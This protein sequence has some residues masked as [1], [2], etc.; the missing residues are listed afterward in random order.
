[1]LYDFVHGQFAKLIF[2]ERVLTS[3]VD[4]SGF[5]YQGNN[6]LLSFKK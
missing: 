4:L 6:E 3:V 2:G 5:I 1:M